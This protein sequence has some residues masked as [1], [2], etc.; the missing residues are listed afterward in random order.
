MGLT[1]LSSFMAACTDCTI[2]F[3][4]IHWYDSAENIAYFK[5]HVQ[6]AY[7][8]GGNRPLWITE[9]QAAGTVDQQNAFMKEVLPWLDAS[10]MVERYSWFMANTNAGG[11]ISGEGLSTLG[12]TFKTS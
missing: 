8:A 7:K 2:D 9:F 6:D 1:W 12:S 10:D 3:V 11:L 4:C 5:S